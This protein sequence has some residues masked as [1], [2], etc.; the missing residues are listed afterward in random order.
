ME[1][2]HVAHAYPPSRGGAQTWIARVSAQLAAQYNDEVKVFT[3]TALNTEHFWG[4]DTAALPPGVEHIDGVTVRRFPV[5]NR[6]N[7]LR[8]LLSG[9][10]YRLRLPFNDY[11]RTWE[12]GP[13]IPGLRRAV[14]TSGADVVLAT[15]F[16]LWHMYDALAGAKR[17]NLP[18]VFMGALHLE[19]AW[20]Y[21]RPMIYR[22]IRAADGYVA[23]TSYERDL[24]VDEYGVAAHKIIV[25][26]SG[27]DVTTPSA[28]LPAELRRRYGWGDAPLILSL[29]KQ[30]S[31]KRF[32]LLLDAMRL[33]W[34]DQSDVYLVIA[35]A[36]TPYAAEIERMIATLPPYARRRVQRLGQ[37]DDTLKAGLLATC[38]CFVLASG[39]ESFGIA[40]VEAW[41][42]G[43]PVIGARH[44]AIAT[45]IAHD[46]DGLLFDYPD[47][48]NLAQQIRR[49]LADP[50]W[51][52]SLGAAG[53]HKMQQYYTW[54]QVTAQ[55]RA[56][57]TQVIQ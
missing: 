14:T 46:V 50:A 13:F 23:L 39:H 18:I 41:A 22:A 28:C 31:R 21:H 36:D 6:F 44:G 15:S 48:S 38:D 57:Y 20:G 1:I 16:P 26:G 10:A 7:R 33:V 55:V 47:P 34:Q 19:D 35:G 45:L 2:L 43:K 56:L 11:L 9:L 37:I 25:A 49:L 53:R 29:G 51:A 24:L 8:W 5:F 32:D 40:F 12:T 42:L 52:Q 17:G 54:P 30:T 27:V 3:T 4:Q